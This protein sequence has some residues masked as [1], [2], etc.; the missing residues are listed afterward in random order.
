MNNEKIKT[1]TYEAQS[2]INYNDLK[3]NS[4]TNK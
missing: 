4:I 2:I 1:F 3:R